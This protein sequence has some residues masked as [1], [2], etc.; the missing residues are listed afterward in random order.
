MGRKKMYLEKCWGGSY[1]ANL[2]RMTYLAQRTHTQRDSTQKHLPVPGVED[3]APS[4]EHFQ[5]MTASEE[6]KIAFFPCT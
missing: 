3:K 4:K 2:G 5:N 6:I 1:K